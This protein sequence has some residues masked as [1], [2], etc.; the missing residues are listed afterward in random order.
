MTLGQILWPL[1]R[2]R[3]VSGRPVKPD[4]RRGNQRANWN[5]TQ[6][7][8]NMR[9]VVARSV[10]ERSPNGESRFEPKRWTI[11][12]H[13]IVMAKEKVKR[14]AFQM[15]AVS[16]AAPGAAHAGAKGPRSRKLRRHAREQCDYEN[17]R[18]SGSLSAD[19]YRPKADGKFPVLLERTPYDK[20]RMK[21][22]RFR[23]KSRRPWLCLHHS[24][25]SRPLRFGR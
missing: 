15:Q 9:E 21:W 24:G 12:P 14:N 22:R 23:P 7:L 11:I 5:A 1:R 20:H 4:S 8:A 2:D 13:E 19:I 6:R 17:S 3:R 18:R 16:H 10:Y 25:L